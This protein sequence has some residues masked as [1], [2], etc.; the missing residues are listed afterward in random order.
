[1]EPGE[2]E[3][4]GW[5]SYDQSF[6]EDAHQLLA[7]G[8]Q[9]ARQQIA[10]GR[11]ETEITGFIVEA[12]QER[13]NSP[14]IDERFD[15]YA[16]MEDNPVPGE[17]RTGKRRM[18]I[19]IIIES[20]FRPRHKLR[21]R[22]IF[23]AKRLRK[24]SH[25]IGLYA[26]QEGLIRFIQGR[27]ASDCPEV[28]MLGYVQTDTADRWIAE[29]KKRF[30]NDSANQLLLTESLLQVTIHPDLKDEWSSHHDRPNS[31]PL[32]VFHLFLDCSAMDT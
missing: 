32:I 2:G 30:E 3:S 22:Y 15:R 25:P 11:E 5:S 12:I 8:Y 27:Y 7:W 19:D 23:E 18:R 13:L 31:T 24:P 4:A 6:R 9:D 29:L 20:S 26:G 21:P 10:P 1:M 16:I 28:V 14:E 17:N